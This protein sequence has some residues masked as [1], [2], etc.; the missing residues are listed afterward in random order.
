[1]ERRVNFLAIG[2]V[3][4]SIL[5]ALVIFIVIMGRFNFDKNEY[6]NYVIYTE[7]EVSG[8]GINTPV[9]Y[10]GITIG[11][12]DHIGFEA[13]K[14]GVVKIIVKIKKTVPIRKNS[15][16]VVDSQGLAGLNYLSLRQNNQG[17]FIKEE[18]DAILNFEPNFFGK[19][20]LKADKIS[21]DMMLLI[22]NLKL[23]LN[24]NNMQHISN[25][26]ES[27]DIL[28]QNL[29]NMQANVAT[30][31]NNMNTLIENL[32]RQVENGDFNAREIL[33]PFMIRLNTSLNYMDQFFKRGGNI[34]E[35]FEK[36][37]YNTIFGEQK[38]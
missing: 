13:D 4:F 15:T 20:S 5:S 6:R 37:P 34:L 33:N 19:L 26:I 7:N 12:I 16:L 27:I 28:S 8:L 29:K 23:L 1:M 32:N 31:S 24:E 3:F 38:K 10:K 17:E 30:L 25:T 9:R 11:S 36:D 2:I 14:L 35:K 22:Q 18:K 21:Q